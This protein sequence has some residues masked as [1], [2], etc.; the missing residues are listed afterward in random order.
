MPSDNGRLI[1]MS[2]GKSIGCG[3]LIIG[4]SVSMARVRLEYGSSMAKT[5]E[6]V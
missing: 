6:D 4:C 5:R 3:C 1:K 2:K